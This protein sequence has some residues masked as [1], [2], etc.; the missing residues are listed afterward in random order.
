MCDSTHL[1]ASAHNS[2][3]Y[4][5]VREL[6]EPARAH[7]GAGVEQPV[8]VLHDGGSRGRRLHRTRH[9]HHQP[10][11]EEAVNAISD[12][13]WHLQYR[14]RT[15]ALSHGIGAMPQ[16]AAAVSEYACR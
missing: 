12:D 15:I 7:F 2:S 16:A 14:Y 8:R 1:L 3:R 5:P 11:I 9:K 6:G 4:L 13:A 10:R